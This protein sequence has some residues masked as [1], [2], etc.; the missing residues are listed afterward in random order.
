MRI[1]ITHPY[2]W[3]EVRRGAER[4]IV[5][6]ARSLAGRHHD[7]TVYTTG[8]P[9]IPGARCVVLRPVGRDPFLRELA[10]GGGV[11]RHLLTG[12][13]DAVH[14]M[15][16]FDAAA[17]V[18]TRSVGGHRVVYEELGIPDRSYWAT[19]RDGRVRRWLVDRVDVYGC[20][21][22]YAADALQTQF[23][24]RGEIIPGGV[25]LDQF[26]PGPRRPEPTILFSGALTE[27][28]K[29]LAVLLEAF[30][31]LRAE[32]GDLR[33][34]L[35]GPGDPSDLL[36]ALPPQVRDGVEQ[37]PVGDPEGQSERYSAA[38]VTALPSTWDSFGLVLIESLAAGTP[39][40]VAND[41]APPSLVTPRTG[42]VAEPGDADSLAEA[43]R[44]GLELAADPATAALCR[45]YAARFDWDSA[46]APLLETLYGGREPAGMTA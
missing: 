14:C 18:A 41:A 38:W 43:L 30:A 28:R 31:L 40:V 35:S 22:R 45:D 11:A 39:I 12:R 15:M 46:I 25:R 32:R 21:S 6:T 34:W 33:L 26:R 5:E 10:F 1:A 20:M 7:V 27:P 16:P 2:S 29:G 4:M 17:A 42:A 37:L 23:G 8:R 13:F 44:R 9:E 36:A 19:R 24:R 3:P